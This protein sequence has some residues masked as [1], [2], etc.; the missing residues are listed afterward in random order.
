M[1]CFFFNGLRAAKK[2]KLYVGGLVEAFKMAVAALQ[3]HALTGE[4]IRDVP[5][6]ER[7]AAHHKIKGLRRVVEAEASEA[8]F[9]DNDGLGRQ[10]L[11][12]ETSLVAAAEPVLV[13][14]SEVVIVE[15]DER[16]HCPTLVELF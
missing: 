13:R 16:G 6:G 5:K 9:Y 15:W 3:F 10:N 12:Q 8:L 4:F 14:V 1:L 2:F 7:T 11:V